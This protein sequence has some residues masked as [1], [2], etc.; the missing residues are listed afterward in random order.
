M[1]RELAVV[2]PEVRAAFEEFDRALVEPAAA[3][4]WARSSSRLR[5]SAKR[6]AKQARRALME[7]DVAQPAVGAACVAMLRLLRE[8]GCEPDMVGG[9]SYGELVALHAAGV[10][11][12]PALAELSQARGRFMREA[13]GGAAGCDGGPPG[14]SG[15]SRAAHPRRSRRAG[16]QLEWSQADGDRRA[17]SMPSS[18]HSTWPQRAEFRADCLPVSSAFHTPLVAPAREPLARLASQLLDQSPDRPVYSNLD[19]AAHP[20]DPAAIAGGW[21]IISPGRCGSPT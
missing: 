21:A 2:F 1:L 13:G 15:R 9:H 4:P 12:A 3:A 17:E 14:R 18:R 16:R 19:A 6:R 20:A 10:M 7:T 11:S 5:P 8:L